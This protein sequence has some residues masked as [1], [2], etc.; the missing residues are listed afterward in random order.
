MPDRPT[1]GL[2]R[3]MARGNEVK[4]IAIAISASNSAVVDGKAFSMFGLICPAA[5]TGTAIHLEVSPDGVTF[6]DLYD[7]FNVQ[8]TVTIAVSRAYDLPAELAVWP[9]WRFVSNGTEAA[10]RTFTVVCKS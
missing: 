9:F 8:S 6:T 3:E 10:A 1:Q 5:L 7:A 2:P 4:S